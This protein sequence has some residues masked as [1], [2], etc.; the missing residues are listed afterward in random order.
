MVLAVARTLTSTNRLLEMKR[1]LDGTGV[2]VVFTVDPGSA[3]SGDSERRL[4]ASGQRLLPWAEAQGPK[5]PLVVTASENVDLSRIRGPVLVLQH[6]VAFGK[7]VPDSESD[8]LRRAGVVPERFLR[9]GRVTMVVGHDDHVA[10]LRAS[11]PETAGRC[12][13]IGDP[14][15]D[16]IVASRRRRARYRRR[17]LVGGRRLVVVTSTWSRDGLFGSWPELY[18]RLLAELPY[19]EYA[20]AAVLHPNIPT[21]HGPDFVDQRLADAHDAGLLRI[22]VTDGWQAAIV[23]ADLV[24]GDSGSVGLYAA[25]AGIPFVLGASGQVDTLG[26]VQAELATTA[27]RLHPSAPLRPQIEQALHTEPDKTLA[28]RLFAHQ[29][30]AAERLRALLLGPLDVA[31]PDRPALARYAPD[32]CPEVTVPR[33]FIVHTRLDGPGLVTM[34]RHP[35]AA[36]R[37]DVTPPGFHRHRAESDA[38]HRLFPGSADVIA[39]PTETPEPDA[40]RWLAEKLDEGAIIAAATIPTGL[41]IHL[42]TGPRFHCTPTD[43]LLAA[44]TLYELTKHPEIPTGPITLHLGPTH[45]TFTLHPL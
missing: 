17:L 23:A 9:T 36:L 13:V 4:R 1:L 32:P 33:T 34:V 39:N 28:D 35:K 14:T 44:S 20:V 37:E 45:H 38:E 25:A 27:P 29:G 18:A 22:P 3:F 15:F 43:P 2:Q 19:D 5:W 11:H 8:G 40:L 7:M 41:L 6:G 42:N 16:Q 21:L 30:T 24:V 26:T 10:E 31:A 12:V